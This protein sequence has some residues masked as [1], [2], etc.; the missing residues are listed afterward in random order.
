MQFRMKQLLLI[1][2]F[3]AAPLALHAQQLTVAGHD[4]QV[5]GFISQ[6]FVDTGTGNN[7]WLTMNSS[8]GS[9]A[10]TDGGVNISTQINDKFRVGA[11]LYDRNLGALGNWHPELDWAVAD[12]RFTSWL[13]VRGGKVKTTFG[14]FNDTQDLDFLHTFALLPQSVYPVDVRDANIAHLGGDVYGSIPLK[15]GLGSL[16]YTAFVGHRNDSMESGISYFLAA[17]GTTEQTYGGLQYGVDLR[18][19]TPLKGVLV[20]ISRLN[21][22]LSGFGLRLAQPNLEK[23]KGKPD[24][25]NQFYG[26]YTRGKL[27]I[28]SEY[29]RFYRDHLIRNLTAEDATNVHAWYISGAY[30]FTKWLELGSYYSRYTITSTFLELHDTSLP[31]GHDYDKVVTG[32]FDI[33][34]FWNVKVEGH[35]MDGYGFGPY[36][37]G[38][39]PQVNPN[40]FKPKTNALVIK[41]GFNF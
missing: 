3:C 7:N 24:F 27:R 16:S 40:G 30:R 10:M 14:L 38:F 36:P 17:R 39:Y 29:K 13:G 22:D 15:G 11:Q 20:G 33:N 19:N 23:T 28:D 1:A 26:E 8:K 9:F 18:W 35:F 21:E 2:A 12:Y 4:V 25:T 37:N 34:R 31:S 6:G 5:H 41:T 32:R